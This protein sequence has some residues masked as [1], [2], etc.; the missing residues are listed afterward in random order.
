MASAAKLTPENKE[1]FN[2]A[3]RT[4]RQD[5]DFHWAHIPCKA[6]HIYGSGP[7]RMRL[8]GTAPGSANILAKYTYFGDANLDGTV[9][10]GDFN[11]IYHGGL[12][13]L[14]GWFNGVAFV[15]DG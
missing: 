6:S 10:G 14:T 4:D 11:R 1:R 2:V 5:K 12:I 7:V 9:D 15:S 8:D 13:N 3:S